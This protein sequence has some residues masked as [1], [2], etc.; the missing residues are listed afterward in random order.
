[1]GTGHCF[2]L[3]TDDLLMPL[4]KPLDV[5]VDGRQQR[6]TARKDVRAAKQQDD[7][8]DSWQSESDNGDAN[9]REQLI[10]ANN[11]APQC[12]IIGIILYDHLR[13]QPVF[14]LFISVSVVCDL[15]S[16]P[17]STA[18]LLVAGKRTPLSQSVFTAALEAR[19]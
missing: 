18:L 8:D 15:V 19:T 5:V 1:M 4:V 11:A 16:F 7:D 3:Q 12:P 13:L 17:L 10:P 2:C 14:L 9:D 6:Q